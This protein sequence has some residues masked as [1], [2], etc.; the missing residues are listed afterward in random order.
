MKFM[1][2]RFSIHEDKIYVAISN[3][4]NSQCIHMHI[5]LATYLDNII[6]ALSLRLLALYGSHMALSLIKG[7][8]GILTRFRLTHLRWQDAAFSCTL[9]RRPRSNHAAFPLAH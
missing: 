2:H 3:I 4:F 7:K 1:L 9:H 5:Y 8:E 6:F